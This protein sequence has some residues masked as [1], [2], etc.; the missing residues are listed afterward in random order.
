MCAHMIL[1]PQDELERIIVDIKNNLKAEQVGILASYQDVYPRAKVPVVV[2][3]ADQLDVQ[4]MQWGY[5]V[6]WQKDVVYNTK[7]ETALSAKPNMWSGSYQNRR[8]L[9]PSFVFFEPHS[10]NLPLSHFSFFYFN[11]YPISSL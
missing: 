6:T 3:N 4:I 9:V 1:I 11:D 5:P 2:S 10:R 8:C 7:M